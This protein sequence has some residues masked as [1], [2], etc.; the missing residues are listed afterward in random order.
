MPKTNQKISPVHLNAPE[1]FM[2]INDMTLVMNDDEIKPFFGNCIILQVALPHLFKA[3]EYLFNCQSAFLRRK[4]IT[5]PATIIRIPITCCCIF[6]LQFCIFMRLSKFPICYIEI[7]NK[8]GKAGMRNGVCGM[9]S[10]I[11]SGDDF[12]ERY[13]I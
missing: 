13:E 5:P 3:P 7:F 1:K 11:A 12:C 8:R 4:F 2:R 9:R 6:I 10:G